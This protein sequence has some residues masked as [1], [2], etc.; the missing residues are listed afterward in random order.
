MQ[1]PRPRTMGQQGRRW[2]VLR[3]AA[4]R[5]TVR[6]RTER[7]EDAYVPHGCEYLL[8]RTVSGP[9][10]GQLLSTSRFA[11]GPLPNIRSIR[12]LP[13]VVR[14]KPMLQLVFGSY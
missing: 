14:S 2:F 12:T 5:R 11:A 8:G 7:S 13:L 4:Q 9:G 10:V 1:A 6:T 3:Q